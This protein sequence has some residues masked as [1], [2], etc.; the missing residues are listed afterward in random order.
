MKDTDKEYLICCEYHYNHILFKKN[1]DNECQHY[2]DILYGAYGISAAMKL[3]PI[4]WKRLYNKHG[5]E[6]LEILEDNIN[7]CQL[8]NEIETKK[9]EKSDANK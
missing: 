4:Y 9:K 7:Y 1:I 2:T 3:E 5:K 8:R 6:A